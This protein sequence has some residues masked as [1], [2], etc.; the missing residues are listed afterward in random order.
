MSLKSSTKV[1]VNTT[2]LVFTADAETFAAAVEKA[3]QRQ[4]KNITVPGFRKGKASRKLI[5][6]YYGEGVFFEEAI[7]NIIN[8]Q[9]PD[10]IKEADLVLVDTPKI[11][12]LSADLEAGVEFKAVCVTKPEVTVAEYKGIKAPKKVKDINDDDINAHIEQ[13]KQRNARIISVDDRACEMKDE[14]V[15]DFEGFID[16]VAFEGGKAEQFPL[17]LGSGQFIPGFEDQVA[18]HSIGEEFDINVTFPETYQM[19][20][21]AGKDATFKVK[22]HAINA[23]EYPEFDDELIKDTTEFDTV[24]EWKADL[25]TKLEAQAESRAE[26]E[27]ENYVIQKVIDMTDGVIPKCMFD[28]RIDGLINDFAF[29]LKQQ[30]MSIDIYLQYTGMDMDSF[31]DTFRDRAENEVKLRLA[32]EKIADNENINPSE[33]EIN[34]KLQEIADA[35][36]MS[37]DEIKNRIPMDDLITDMRATAALEVVKENAVVDNTIETDK[38]DDEE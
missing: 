34:A 3:F 28:H 5:E 2:E 7:N 21:Y 35:N 30:G 8:E 26:S 16:G 23:T 10:A 27:F 4:K 18:G 32:L 25:K 12:V 36:N 13:I 14:V 1:D 33:D 11:E 17:K 37:V 19:E 15:I 38:K 22:I 24:D 9:V 6:K 31:R 20:E 29:N